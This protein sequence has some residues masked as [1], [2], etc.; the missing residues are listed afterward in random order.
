MAVDK[1]KVIAEA[2]KFAQRGQWDKAIKAYDRILAEDPKDVRVLL[3]VGELHQKRGD[4]PAAAATFNRVAEAYTDQGFF[5]KAIAVYKQMVKLVPDDV[6]VNERLASLYQQLGIMSDAMGQLQLVAQAAERAGDQGKLLDVLR[7]MTELEPDNVG[8]AVKLGEIH[9]RQGNGAEALGQF[10]RAADLLKR[11]NRAEEYLRV[12]ERIA[13]L[14]PDDIGLTK[15]LANIYLAKGDTK[16]ALAKLQLCFKAEPKDIDTLNLLAQAFRDLGQVGK[17]VSVFKE[18][19]HVYAE[20]GRAGEARTTWQRVLELAPGDPEAAGALRAAAPTRGSPPAARAP[21][22]PTPV[23]GPAAPA[24][25]TLGAEAIPKLL[26]ETDVYVKYGLHQKALD[27]LRKVFDIDP[28]HLDAREKA[29]DIR[30]ASGDAA[31]AAAEAVRLVRAALDASRADRAAAG[32]AKLREIAP[33][34]FELAGLEARSGVAVPPEHELVVEPAEADEIVIET[35]AVSVDDDAVALAAADEAD[36]QVV[37]DDV[38]AVADEVADGPVIDDEPLGA[39]PPFP[40][41]VVSITELAPEPIPLPTPVP[42]PAVAREPPVPFRRPTPVPSPAPPPAATIALLPPELESR[43]TP[44][45]APPPAPPATV[46]LPPPP[47]LELRLTP[48][49]APPPAPPAMVVLPPPPEPELRL[50]PPP[51]PLPAPPATEILHPPPERRWRLTPP[52]APRPGPEVPADL[53]DELG[54]ADFF[55]QQGLVEEARETLQHLLALHPDHADVIARLQQLDRRATPVPAPAP[56]P[57]EPFDIGKELAAE[58]GAGPSPSP[59]EFQYTVDEVFTQFKKGVAQTVRAEDTDTHYDLGIAYKEMGLVDDA[60]QEFETALRGASKKKE[61]DCL[62]MVALCRQEKGDGPGAVE[63]WRRALHSDWL[64]PEAA[65]AM[66]YDL[67]LYYREASDR[68]A[69]LWYLNK[70]VRADRGFRDAAAMLVELG[71]G[72]G[73]PPPGEE[74]ALTPAP[75]AARAGPKNIGYV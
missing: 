18:L 33:D 10:R 32:V 75:S 20:V 4:E 74:P 38:L 8:S 31:G 14:A 28:D 6:R 15:E 60:L 45:P 61:V 58:L 65:R 52:P 71:S 26:T 3:K 67:A 72:P 19:A 17:T 37:E 62:A 55:L 59:E 1:N 50:P 22:P 2:T 73:R 51:A 36:E 70:V 24:Q 47:E 39:A 49:P 44:P 42:R 35:A 43:L 5:L 48:P 68:E 27:H 9:A 41:P 12:A 23:L 63:A 11:N 69:A 66:H 34:H 57:G 30:L 7:R 16:R 29:R 46:I 25:R 40:E 64:T 21:A 53:S 13:F 54:E 56:P